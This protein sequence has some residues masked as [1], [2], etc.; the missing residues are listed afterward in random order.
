MKNVNLLLLVMVAGSSSAWAGDSLPLLPTYFPAAGETYVSMSLSHT[1]QK[2]TT[3]TYGTGISTS[4]PNSTARTDATSVLMQYG[5]SESLRIGIAGSYVDANS[6]PSGASS[7]W[8]SP[9]ISIAKDVRS[10]TSEIA[11]VSFGFTPKIGNTPLNGN[12]S[13]SITGRYSMLLGGAR[14]GTVAAGYL[15]RPGN[16]PDVTSVN[17]SVAEDFG[18]YSA[19][20]GLGLSKT[21]DSHLNIQSHTD[22]NLDYLFNVAISGR[23]T[24]AWNWVAQYT[25]GT[26]RSFERLDSGAGYLDSSSRSHGIGVSLVAKF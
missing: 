12:Q 3:A 8:A 14:W 20:L 23:V 7:G 19:L 2:S 6:A 24:Q 11:S 22:R 16:A 26:S 4:S 5:L 13:T 17:F 18:Q 25:Y 10:S 21:A 15:V 9:S 1:D